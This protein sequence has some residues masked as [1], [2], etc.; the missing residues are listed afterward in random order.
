MIPL[1]LFL[2]CMTG[3]ALYLVTLSPLATDRMDGHGDPRGL[4]RSEMMQIIEGVRTPIRFVDLS[5]NSYPFWYLGVL[6]LKCGKELACK[7]YP[8]LSE[9]AMV[10]MA[11][12]NLVSP[13][14]NMVVCHRSQV[15][16]A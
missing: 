5:R 12:D 16:H 2:A 7:V 11:P 9:E 13:D 14:Y 6:Y 4:L 8:A 10:T 3:P 1:P 15:K